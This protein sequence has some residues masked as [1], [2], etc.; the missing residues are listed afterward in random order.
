MVCWVGSAFTTGR[1]MKGSPNLAGSVWKAP[2]CAMT[3]NPEMTLISDGPKVAPGTATTLAIRWVGFTTQRRRTTT[4][5]DPNP[6]V[7]RPSWKLAFDAIMS[8]AA[9]E[10]AGSEAAGRELIVMLAIC[11]AAATG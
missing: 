6:T 1:P 8:T 10:A 5:S 7:T 3:W 9:D 11:D 4:S 2:G